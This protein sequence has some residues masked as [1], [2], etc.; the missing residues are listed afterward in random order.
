MNKKIKKVSRYGCLSMSCMSFYVHFKKIQSTNI[1]YH[2]FITQ[3]C[4]YWNMYVH[5][6]V[7]VYDIQILGKLFFIWCIRDIMHLAYRQ[8]SIF[9][10]SAIYHITRHTKFF[11]IGRFKCIQCHC[12]YRSTRVVCSSSCV[13]NWYP[14]YTVTIVFWLKLFI[15]F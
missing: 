7:H 2:T 12:Q 15:D 6:K 8:F 1:T 13:H 3:C 11:L 4:L 10:C 5:N 9:L 14:N